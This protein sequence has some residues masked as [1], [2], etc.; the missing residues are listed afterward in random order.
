MQLLTIC[1][2]LSSKTICFALSIDLVEKWH[3]TI[4]IA[5]TGATYMEQFVKCRKQHSLCENLSHKKLS[6]VFSIIIIFWWVLHYCSIWNCNLKFS[7]KIQ[8][9]IL[10]MI[11]GP[12]PTH[13]SFL[14]R[15]PLKTCKMKNRIMIKNNNS[16]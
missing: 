1:F 10:Y 7:Q 11:T 6:S 16:F 2:A 14:Y 13:F 15:H 8:N 9:N 3:I 4:S 5:Y 12:W